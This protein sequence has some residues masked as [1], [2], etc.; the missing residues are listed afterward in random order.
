MP[1][2]GQMGSISKDTWINAAEPQYATANASQ[3]QSKS[4][5]SHHSNALPSRAA[6]NIFWV[7]R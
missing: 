4:S 3:T 6:D 7:G 2:T 1:I 5:R